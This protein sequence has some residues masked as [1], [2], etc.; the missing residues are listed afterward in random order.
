MT[1]TVV[2]DHRGRTKAGKE[3][4]LE[5]RIT[6]NGK[7]YYI[8]TDIKVRG[9][10]FK[11][12]V[13]VNRGDADALN[14]RLKIIV[15]KVDRAVTRCIERGEQIDVKA[16]KEQIYQI[17]EAE[18]KD[19]T[20]LVDWVDEQIPTLNVNE[21]TRSHFRV[22]SKRLREFCKLNRWQDLTI[23]RL[24]EWD[25]WLHNLRRPLSK[26][27]VQAG[28]EPGKITQGSVHNYHKDLRSLM[29][30]A[31]RIG[32]IDV[33]PY[34]KLSGEF[35][36]GDYESVEFLNEEEMAAIVSL[37]PI[38]GTQ[39]AMARDLFVFQMYTG[40]A[41][42]DAQAFDIKN[43]KREFVDGIDGQKTERWTHVGERIKTG[44]PYVSQ[45]LPPVIDVLKRYGWHT[46]KIEN[47][48]YNQCLKVIQQALGISSRMH[49][50]LAR[51]TFATWMLKNGV[52]IE[53]V[54]KMVGH[55]NIRQT[56]RYAKVMPTAVYDDFEKV[57][58]KMS[59]TAIESPDNK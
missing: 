56:Q 15:E 49:S 51:H 19:S 58:K 37:H 17:E 10:E 35:P 18:A 16:I 25:A 6:H 46:P 7:P 47:G 4:P 57:A 39:M 20:T 1:K 52:P 50:H 42:S 30:R 43:Y 3:G 44:V 34:D 48:Q 22:M 28:R 2:F 27:D 5:V 14:D 54:S 9:R 8:N 11:H 23:E 21:R 38:E 53:H 31:A 40:L 29:A 24:Y 32:K 45:L 13:I 26:A 41:Y 33:N 55:T 59:K 36:K 12:G